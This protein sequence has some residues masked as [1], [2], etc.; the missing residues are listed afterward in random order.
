MAVGSFPSSLL[1]RLH[2]FV[3]VVAIARIFLEGE[4]QAVRR[5]LCVLRASMDMPHVRVVA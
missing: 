5:S 4:R 3:I 2:A 1:W